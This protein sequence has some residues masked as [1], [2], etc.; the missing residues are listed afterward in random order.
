MD[1]HFSKQNLIACADTVSPY[2]RSLN[3]KKL[4][5]KGSKQVYLTYPFPHRITSTCS[6]FQPHSSLLYHILF[7]NLHTPTHAKS[8]S[9]SQ[10]ESSFNTPMYEVALSFASLLWTRG[11]SSVLLL[12]TGNGFKTCTCPGK[13]DCRP[14]CMLC[15]LCFSK[16]Y[17]AASI[18][19]SI[20]P[21]N[22]FQD[23]FGM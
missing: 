14:W 13:H 11:M 2:D 15:R 23:W 1:Q 4:S 6:L 9:Y 21:A 19:V 8:V 16:Q 18:I 7:N 5:S 20:K 3:C 17:C 10:P 12:S 22:S